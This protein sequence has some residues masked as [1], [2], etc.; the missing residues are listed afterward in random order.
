MAYYKWA[1]LKFFCQ[2]PFYCEADNEPG[3][4]E[5]G[6]ICEIDHGLAPSISMED[7]LAVDFYPS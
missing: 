6:N 7:W 5:T 4:Q 1:Y 3:W 2:L